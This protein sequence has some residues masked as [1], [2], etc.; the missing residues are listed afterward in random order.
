H[1]ENIEYG[2]V[3]E[4]VG[5]QCHTIMIE[6][7]EFDYQR[8]M[9]ELQKLGYVNVTMLWFRIPG[10]GAKSGGLRPL[11]NEASFKELE[12]YVYDEGIVNIY[13]LHK[14]DK[15]E[16]VS[17]DELGKMMNH[18]RKK[19]TLVGGKG[20]LPAEANSQTTGTS[21]QANV[22]H[23]NAE[24]TAANEAKVV[25][26]ECLS[27]ELTSSGHSYDDDDS[28]E[29]ESY[30]V[31][32]KEM[33]EAYV[34]DEWD[35]NKGKGKKVKW[36]ANIG[37]QQNET[38]EDDVNDNV[39]GNEYEHNYESDD[40]V[41]WHDILEEELQYDD[42]EMREYR[43]DSIG[44]GRADVGSKW[45]QSES[46][47]I[48][49]GTEVQAQETHEE[50]GRGEVIDNTHTEGG[51]NSDQRDSENEDPCYKDDDEDTAIEIHK[52]RKTEVYPTFNE[53]I[54]MFKVELVV[55]Q[56]F[57]S[58]HIFKQAILAYSIQQ[59]KD[60]V[61]LKNDKRFISIGCANCRWKITF[62]PDLEDSTGWQIKSM[63]PL[64]ER[65]TRTFKNR[66]IT[67]HWLV[68]EF[69]DKILRNPLMKAIEMKEDMK[70]RYDIVVGLRKCRRAKRKALNV[71]QS[72]MEK[73][74]GILKPYLN[75]LNLLQPVPGKTFWNHEGEGL[76]LPPDII[77]KG[78]GKKKTARRKDGD[79]PSKGKV[80]YN[81]KGFP[82]KGRKKGSKNRV[83]RPLP[84]LVQAEVP[85]PSTY[86][87]QSRKDQGTAAEPTGRG[88]ASSSIGWLEAARGRGRGKRGRGR[89]RG[90]GTP[91]GIGLIYGEGGT[92]SFSGSGNEPPV[93][94]SHSQMSSQPT[95]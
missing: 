82:S 42:H 74:H 9:E 61:Y 94:I 13:A 66:L 49:G 93:V 53:K 47:S 7:V 78:L 57:T 87:Q 88:A 55:G 41:P 91:V 92:I 6:K 81:R 28:A 18:P 71:V 90:R 39:D 80:K 64:D 59:H 27:D 76:V 58:R 26:E 65:C 67:E 19:L 11:F 5:G 3:D 51:Y 50:E 37:R 22:D 32:P 17:I 43:A 30:K 60:L 95:Q 69:L 4:Y 23:N 83:G 75:E 38:V 8:L 1:G 15:P 45:C 77:R 56:R 33:K 79:E 48:G 62:G 63:Q 68:N 34:E 84:D 35:I 44:K 14:V 36:N 20:K 21:N 73:Q 24:A 10:I 25:V 31:N 85:T 2:L 54:D 16:I 86:Q 89:S 52:R 70:V 12:G 46:A 72:L 40:S 29:D